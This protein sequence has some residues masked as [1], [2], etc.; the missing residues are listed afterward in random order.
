M[1]AVEPAI[2]LDGVS[3][4]FLGEHGRVTALQGVSFD[5][6][7]SSFIAL[8]GPSGCGKSTVLNVVAGLTAPTSGRVEC[9][10]RP[11]RGINTAVGYATQNSNLFPW[12]TLEQNIAF[13]LELRGVPKAERR[14]R[15][16]EYLA[17]TGLS[18]FARAYP[19][20]LSGGMQKRASIVRTV[21][22]DPGVILMDEPFGSL[23]AQTRMVLQHELLKIWGRSRKTVL[24]VTHDLV[25]AIGLSD[26]VIVFSGRPARVREVVDVPLPRPRDV[27]R[28]H[29]QEGFAATYD[30][31]WSVFHKELEIQ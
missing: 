8:V 14:R 23:D 18:G 29:E 6:E 5:V 11:V 24:F 13:P 30:R 16:D 12:L 28:I 4:V 25:E 1:A 3:K 19:Y 9:Q 27:F 22:Y 21:I 17:M 2:R 10:G 26:R 15:I 31:I 7:E 20:Q